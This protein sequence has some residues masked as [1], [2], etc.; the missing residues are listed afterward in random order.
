MN[1]RRSAQPRPG[2]LRGAVEAIEN[3][4]FGGVGNDRDSALARESSE[5]E[6]RS[7]SPPTIT[8][9]RRKRFAPT[10]PSERRPRQRGGPSEGREPRLSARVEQILKGAH[11]DITQ[12]DGKQAGENSPT[13]QAY[14]EF[15]NPPNSDPCIQNIENEKNDEQASISERS[16]DSRQMQF[17]LPKIRIN[18]CQAAQQVDLRPVIYQAHQSHASETKPNELQRVKEPCTDEHLS[19]IH[20]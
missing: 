5:N 18:A 2:R 8:F 10:I 4:T 13:H 20:I 7:T 3:Q 1:D 16:A 12:P 17:R 11:V 19:L 14:R 15:M 9:V 6:N